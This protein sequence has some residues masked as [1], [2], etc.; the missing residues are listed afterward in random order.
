MKF[1]SDLQDIDFYA[2]FGVKINPRPKIIRAIS[3]FLGAQ[4]PK[5]A[6]KAR[7][8]DTLIAVVESTL[9]HFCRSLSSTPFCER[10]VG[11]FSNGVE[12]TLDD[13]AVGAL[14]CWSGSDV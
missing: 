3:K 9:S 11:P 12:G 7:S 10:D 13:V 6:K 4:A 2:V 14:C 8:A 1:N 5:M